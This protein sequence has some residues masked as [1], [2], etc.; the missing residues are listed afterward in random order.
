MASIEQDWNL[1]IVIRVLE[2]WRGRKGGIEHRICRD[3]VTLWSTKEPRDSAHAPCLSPVRLL[4]PSATLCF[5]LVTHR[6]DHP[7][8][9]SALQ[10]YRLLH[11]SAR[12]YIPTKA[13]RVF[14]QKRIQ[15][16]FR[17]HMYERDPIV[18]NSLLHRA[19]SALMSSID[20]TAR[21]RLQNG[22]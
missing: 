4:P 12:M 16:E 9:S 11:R 14:A 18:I 21:Q 22:Q 15:S 7:M 6:F 13:G 19:Y 2:R 1:D 17:A 3:F 10:L 20:D 8:S 5:H